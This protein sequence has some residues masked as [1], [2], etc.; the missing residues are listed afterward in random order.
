[1]SS[2]GMVFFSPLKAVNAPADHNMMAAM[3]KYMN[4]SQLISTF[5]L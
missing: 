2:D 4:E 1:V 5:Y 3:A